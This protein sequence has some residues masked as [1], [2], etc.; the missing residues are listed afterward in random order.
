MCTEYKKMW[1]SVT[2]SNNTASIWKLSDIKSV[3]EVLGWPQSDFG[4]PLATPLPLLCKQ[5]DVS[6]LN[7]MAFSRLLSSVTSTLNHFFVLTESCWF[8][9]F[10]LGSAHP[11]SLAHFDGNVSYKRSYHKS[12]HWNNGLPNLKCFMAWNVI[13]LTCP[14]SCSW[15]V[16]ADT[17]SHK[18]HCSV[19]DNVSPSKV[20]TVLTR[21]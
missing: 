2:G 5:A 8:F 17:F 10:L 12:N 13:Y 11:Y 1:W 19:K 3:P 15:A 7:P 6:L 16:R 4:N 21:I 14:A 9:F 20:I 18:M